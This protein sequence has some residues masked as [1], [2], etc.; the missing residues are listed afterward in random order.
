VEIRRDVQM[1]ENKNYYNKAC[2]GQ[3]NECRLEYVHIQIGK[4][5]EI[6]VCIL[7]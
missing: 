3:I 5:M 2:V 4:C 7:I 1:P 6:H